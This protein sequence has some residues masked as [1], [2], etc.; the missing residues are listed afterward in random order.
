MEAVRAAPTQL[1]D[2]LLQLLGESAPVG[3]SMNTSRGSP[4][5]SRQSIIALTVR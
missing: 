3:S 4:V 5:P 1:H 2:P